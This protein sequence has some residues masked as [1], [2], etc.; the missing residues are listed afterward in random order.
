MKLLKQDAASVI[1]KAL[2]WTPP[3]EW[4]TAFEKNLLHVGDETTLHIQDQA[5]DAESLYT[6]MCFES[7]PRLAEQQLLG[8][9]QLW[10]GSS[11][12]A[13]MICYET[14]HDAAPWLFRTSIMLEKWQHCC[15]VEFWSFVSF[16]NFLESPQVQAQIAFLHN[17]MHYWDWA[18]VQRVSGDSTSDPLMYQHTHRDD[19]AIHP[20]IARQVAL[21][22]GWGKHAPMP[23]WVN[24]TL[25]DVPNKPFFVLACSGPA[26]SSF[27][28]AWLRYHRSWQN[29]APLLFP[30]NQKCL[31][32]VETITGISD[33][34]LYCLLEYYSTSHFVFGQTGFN[35]ANA[36]AEFQKFS[37]TQHAWFHVKKKVINA[38][39]S[40]SSVEAPRTGLRDNW[41]LLQSEASFS[42]AVSSKEITA[43]DGVYHAW[44]KSLQSNS[45]RYLQPM[46]DVP[47]ISDLHV[48]WGSMYSV[49]CFSRRA[50]TGDELNQILSEIQFTNGFHCY[51]VAHDI[52]PW[53]G[54]TSDLL[55]RWE[56]CCTIE[57]GS[58]RAFHEKMHDHAFI[59]RVRR[60]QAMADDFDWALSRKVSGGVA[61]TPM[62]WDGKYEQFNSHIAIKTAKARGWYEHAEMPAFLSSKLGGAPES[63]WVLTAGRLDSPASLSAWRQSQRL[64]DIIAPL[65]LA[66]APFCVITTAALV[67]HNLSRRVVCLNEYKSAAHF[68]LSESGTVHIIKQAVL[69]AYRPS[70]TAWLHVRPTTTLARN[71]DQAQSYH[72]NTLHPCQDIAMIVVVSIFIARVCQ[73][74]SWRP[75]ALM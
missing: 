22:V 32:T 26:N 30:H 39:P 66:R 21:Q 64:F 57:L 65:V 71:F 4:A 46:F 47:G 29:S 24:T 72:S 9:L 48:D 58:L 56:S 44:K 50:D 11:S 18:I 69:R 45:S 2:H 70:I 35:F 41:D 6:V 62:S 42:A 13:S 54:K 37:T 36:D 51:T 17:S 7:S 53:V 61:G 5:K 33:Q 75:N 40:A 60:I 3:A 55:Q 1:A 38:P 74:L 73:S 49:L 34:R 43:A 52:A 15:V 27:I 12:I 14:L 25:S 28:T 59:S 31:R 68:A 19:P 10:S 20:S 23:E 63:V 8:I 67:G 16:H